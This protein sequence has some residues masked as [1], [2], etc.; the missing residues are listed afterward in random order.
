MEHR[1]KHHQSKIKKAARIFKEKNIL[2][3]LK[4][5]KNFL[6]I[7]VIYFLSP[8]IIRLRKRFSEN[9]FT[10]NKTDL[11]YFYHK[12]NLTFTNERAIEL[13]IISSY[14]SNYHHDDILE[15]GAVTNHYLESNWK[16]ID[17]FEVGQSIHNE[18]IEFFRTNKKYKFIFSI[19]TLEHVG[20][21][22]D[23]ENIDSNKI[24]R[25]FNNIIDNLLD[26]NGVFI[27]TIPLGYNHDL[28]NKIINKHINL[29]H[30]NF[31]KKIN[32]KNNWK[33][34][35]IS[36]VSRSDYGSVFSGA[37]ELLVGTIE[38]K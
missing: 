1:Y 38:N 11:P 28:D 21:D 36:E 3:F 17:K 10:F 18:D 13:S 20:V 29:T 12:H 37:G 16:I 22:D 4:L 30:T 15:I 9:Y 19:S 24:D 35:S 25:V 27:F 6:V 14:L 8:L 32:K 31:Y 23:I 7:K 2:E 33:E 5:L 26:D 34:V